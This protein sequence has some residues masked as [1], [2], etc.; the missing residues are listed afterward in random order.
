[1]KLVMAAIVA[2]LFLPPLAGI[3]WFACALLGASFQSLVT[4][5]G[6]LGAPAGIA[7]WWVILFAPALAYAILMRH[8]QG[9]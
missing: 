1:M 3:A 9:L 5:G 4:F 2:T 6:V 8:G 7:A